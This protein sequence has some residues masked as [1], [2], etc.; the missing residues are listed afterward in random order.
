MSVLT[1]ALS[2][3]GKEW[4]TEGW[5]TGT[6][7]KKG[8]YDFFRVGCYRIGEF[9]E[10]PQLN[11]NC[12]FL[13]LIEKALRKN[14]IPY[15]VIDRTPPNAFMM[16]DPD[17]SVL[18]EYEM[19][20]RQEDALR[21]LLAEERARLTWA[22]GT[23]K[24]AMIEMIC[25]LLPKSRIV[26][27]TRANAT[28]QTIYSYIRGS[29]SG[30][31]IYYGSKKQPGRRVTCVS[32]GCLK[33]ALHTLQPQVL[34]CDEVHEM[35][36]P[37]A[38]EDLL[39][40]KYCRMFGLTANEKDR[41]DNADFELQGL[42]GKVVDRLKYAEAEELKMVVP[43]QVH[44]RTVKMKKNPAEDRSSGVPKARW[45][46]WRNKVRNKMI[47]ADA[48]LF[49]DDQVLIV[50]KT[51]EH[52]VYLKQ[53]LPDFKLVY[54]K[55]DDNDVDF[56]VNHS[57]L[58]ER[59]RSMTKQMRDK[60]RVQF[61]TGKLKKVIATSVWNRGVNFRNLGVLIRADGG[62]STI[63]ATQIPGRLSRT[64]TDTE[65]SCGILID[66][67]D[68]FDLGLDRRSNMRKK[69]YEKHGWKQI[70]EGQPGHFR[71][72]D[73]VEGPRTNG[74]PGKASVHPPSKDARGKADRQGKFL[75]ARKQV[76]RRLRLGRK[77][78]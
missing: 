39:K 70:K 12:G 16:E 8:H 53:Y 44:W 15:K 27:T 24:S 25:R 2:Y 18:A 33:Y 35:A 30:C 6:G 29:V 13:P 34:L 52:A 19:R 47:A 69:D 4:V 56:Y 45:G 46:I 38:L 3:M 5:D 57:M 68:V 78:A 48:N 40:F 73:I 58:P 63:D 17:W 20:P 54:G 62:S 66:Y 28:L 23:G 74:H 49:P 65:K 7:R 36:T 67:K 41:E 60:L 59:Y 71:G 31:G 26:I 37:K 75:F 10:K 43:I 42:F 51:I 55:I 72:A 61:E 32:L 9:N 50:V 22:T 76:G 64:S 1:D 14:S 77:K 11:T 21:A